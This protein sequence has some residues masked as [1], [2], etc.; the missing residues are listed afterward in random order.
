[1]SVWKWRNI[2]KVYI[3]TRYN[4]E[5]NIAILAKMGHTITHQQFAEHHEQL[6]YE[7]P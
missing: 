1:M 3:K 7:M 6:C 4:L 2:S 5:F